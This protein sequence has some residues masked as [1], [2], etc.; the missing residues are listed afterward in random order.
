MNHESGKNAGKIFTI[1]NLLSILRICMI[2]LFIWL[3]CAKHDCQLTALILLLSGLTDVMDGYIARRFHMVSDLGK[4]LDPL[5]DKLTQAAMLFCLLTQFPMMIIPLCLLLLKE[6]STGIA[7]LTVIQKTGRIKGAKW[8][9][10]VTTCFLY[11]MMLLHL[12]WPTIPFFVST[13]TISLCVVMMLI[14]YVLYIRQ[15]IYD[16]KEAS[17]SKDDKP[18]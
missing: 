3:Y 6:I 11:G 5:A 12:F 10:K 8:H 18:T 9:G 17:E 13:F 4:V 15:N 14:S 7:T 1:P 2:P 16:F